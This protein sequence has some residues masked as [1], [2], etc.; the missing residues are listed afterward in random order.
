MAFNPE[1]VKLLVCL[2]DGYLEVKNQKGQYEYYVGIQMELFD[3]TFTVASD[4]DDTETQFKIKPR[5]KVFNTQ[6]DVV[7]LGGPTE[8]FS[9][10]S[11]CEQLE[12]LKP[13]TDIKYGLLPIVA[14][15]RYHEQN[16]STPLEKCADIVYKAYVRKVNELVQESENPFSFS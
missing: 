10:V 4:I 8:F 5:V 2:P 14:T 9:D 6:D 16:K 7:A 1:L 13:I 3:H 12:V 15:I 11:R